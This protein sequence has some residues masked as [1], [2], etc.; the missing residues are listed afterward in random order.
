MVNRRNL[1]I[2]WLQWIAANT[3]SS[4][5]GF[6]FAELVQHNLIDLGIHDPNFFTCITAAVLMGSSQWLVLRNRILRL[7]PL[8]IVTSIIGLC[9]SSYLIRLLGFFAFLTNASLSFGE[10]NRRI[11]Y[12]GIFGGFIG[13]LFVGIAQCLVLRKWTSWILINGIAW[14]L[15][16]ATALTTTRVVDRL[17]YIKLNI[18]DVSGSIQ[19]MM[20][21]SILGFISSLFTGTYLAWLLKRADV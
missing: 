7:H 12:N 1:Q 13:G 19:L 18:L 17:L 6:A 3:L 14:S 20:F 16:W 10:T 9:I 4:G 15:A 21:G 5:A 2:F 8:W 11:F